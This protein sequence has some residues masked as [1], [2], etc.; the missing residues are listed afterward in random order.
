MK[1]ITKNDEQ[2]A[3]AAIMTR[4]NHLVRS[5]SQTSQLPSSQTSPQ[6]NLQLH[7]QT[8][9]STKE[10][11]FLVSCVLIN[12]ESNWSFVSEQLNKWMKHTTNCIGVPFSSSLS[13]LGCNSLN[14]PSITLRTK[15]V[16]GNQ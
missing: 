5:S 7:Q 6:S 4:K 1:D 15:N 3:S 16:S 9:W 2:T 13:I 8:K 12:G 10:R 11:L 14:A